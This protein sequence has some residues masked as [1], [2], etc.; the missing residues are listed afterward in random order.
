MFDPQEGTSEVYTV[1]DLIEIEL[2]SKSIDDIE[3]IQVDWEVT[4]YSDREINL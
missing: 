1:Y 4:D 2:T 3:P